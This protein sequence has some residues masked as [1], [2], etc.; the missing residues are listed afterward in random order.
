MPT[1]TETID[2]L[3]SGTLGRSE[4][5]DALATAIE[6]LVS[7]YPVDYWNSPEGVRLW[8]LW[9]DIN[10]DFMA[11]V[12]EET[13]ELERRVLMGDWPEFDDPWAYGDPFSGDGF[14][15]PPD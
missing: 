15:T 10:A 9:E 1:L 14:D 4:R 2:V 3:E 5:I 8:P 13:F 6:M 12:A 7:A 11:S